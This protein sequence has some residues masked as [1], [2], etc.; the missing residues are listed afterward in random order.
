MFLE[1]AA[2]R[3][4]T[5]RQGHASTTLAKPWRG[6]RAEALVVEDHVDFPYPG[7]AQGTVPKRTPD[8]TRGTGRGQRTGYLAGFVG[9]AARPS[10]QCDIRALVCVM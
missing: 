2:S 7:F 1:P 9:Q 8:R 10:V 3:C 5:E 6:A 4:V